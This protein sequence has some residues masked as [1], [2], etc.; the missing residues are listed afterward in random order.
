M[1]FLPGQI[2]QHIR[3]PVIHMAEV[4]ARQQIAPLVAFH[5]CCRCSVRGIIRQ[6]IDGRPMCTAFGQAICMQ[7]QEQIR[8]CL[9]RQRN[10]AFQRD[11]VVVIPRQLHVKLP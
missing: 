7:R 6:D 4:T 2:Q 8:L 1:G 10:P 5:Q 3:H 9:M 11:K